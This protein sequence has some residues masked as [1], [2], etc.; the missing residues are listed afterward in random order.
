MGATSWPVRGHFYLY[1]EGVGFLTRREQALVLRLAGELA[2][3]FE[4]GLLQPADV[5]AY[6]TE[7]VEDVRRAE[8]FFGVANRLGE[9]AGARVF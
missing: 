3:A 8:A 5:R 9:K 6:I 2:P 7:K 1:L 4:E